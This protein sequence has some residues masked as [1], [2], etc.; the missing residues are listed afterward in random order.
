MQFALKWYVG[1]YAATA[2]LV[3]RHAMKQN[4][5]QYAHKIF[6]YLKKSVHNSLLVD[7]I[8]SK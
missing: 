2:L 5:S 3:S 1:I 6:T 7:P 4:F 8:P